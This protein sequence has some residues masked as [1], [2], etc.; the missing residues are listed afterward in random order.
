MFHFTP[1]PTKWTSE[2]KIASAESVQC[3]IYKLV[4]ALFLPNSICPS[5]TVVIILH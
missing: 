3:I 2:S 1:N 5:Q 4:H